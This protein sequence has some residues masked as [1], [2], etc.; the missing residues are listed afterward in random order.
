MAWG[1]QPRSST[2]LLSPL[3]VSHT[4]THIHPLAAVGGESAGVVGALQNLETGAVEE[5]PCDDPHA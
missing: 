3:I 5:P 2:S 1:V 4:P